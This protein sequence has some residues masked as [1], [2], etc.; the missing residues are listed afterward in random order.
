MQVIIFSFLSFLCGALASEVPPIESLRALYGP[1][2]K[3]ASSLRDVASLCTIREQLREG[4]FAELDNEKEDMIK[5]LDETA[6]ESFEFDPS[7]CE[8][9]KNKFLATANYT[10]VQSWINGIP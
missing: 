5:F 3:Q 9:E 4:D 10:A 1:H 8:N 7:V 6:T 2:L